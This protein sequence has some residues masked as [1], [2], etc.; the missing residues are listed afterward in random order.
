MKITKLVFLGL[1]LSSSLAAQPVVI[2]NQ[3]AQDAGKRVWANECGGRIDGLTSWNQGENFAS[4]GIGHFIWYHKGG[5]GP[6]DES[7]P[8][9]IQYL[10]EQGVT[11]PDWLQDAPSCPWTSRQEFLADFH[12]ERLKGLRRLL[13]DTVP[14]QARFIALRMEAA[15][16]KMLESAPPAQRDTIRQRF[17]QVL[18]SPGGLY[19]LL[20]YVNFKGEGVKASERYKGQ[21]WG[22][23]QV[24]MEM[25]GEQLRQSPTLAFAQSAERVLT[26]RVDNSP[27]ERGERRWLQGWK[28]RVRGYA[29]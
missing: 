27:P 26:R 10:K 8:E 23:L 12:G 22:L 7:F 11:L 3:E 16:P 15:L 21:G 4:L 24:L 20:D 6:F 9:L 29:R 28:N 14:H 13:V 2:S 5:E 1:L 19:P 17:R 25:D 18:Q